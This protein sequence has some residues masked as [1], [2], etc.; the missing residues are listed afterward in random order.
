MGHSVDVNQNVYTPFS[1]DRRIRAAN[2]VEKAL[3]M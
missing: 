1:L 3:V 2:A